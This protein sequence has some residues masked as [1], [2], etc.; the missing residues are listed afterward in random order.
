MDF[1]A[2]IPLE[3]R[4]IGQPFLVYPGGTELPIQKIFGNT[5]G[6]LRLACAAVVGVL[7]GRLYVLRSADAQ[8]T[9]II[10]VD[11]LVMPQVV[12]DAS[13][14]LVRAVHVNLLNLCSK[15]LILGGSTAQLAGNPF[16][17]GTAGHPK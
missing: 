10:D 13:A 1:E 12:V 2:L 14:A 11:T 17:V 5:L 6:V 3:F 9:L 8:H 15:P 7:D 4:H 16:I